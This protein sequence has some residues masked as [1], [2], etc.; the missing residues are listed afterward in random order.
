MQRQLRRV[1][2]GP[3]PVADDDEI[4][5]DSVPDSDI[6]ASPQDRQFTV[7]TISGFNAPQVWQPDDC[8]RLRFQC[9]FDA[10]DETGPTFPIEDGLRMILMLITGHYYQNREMLGAADAKSGLQAVELG[11]T[12]LLGAYRQFW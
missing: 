5:W 7:R 4:V 1:A 3:R 8:V 9:G 10:A 2:L 12:S 11:A 6:W